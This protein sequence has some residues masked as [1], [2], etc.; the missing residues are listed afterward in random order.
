MR[1]ARKPVL[2]CTTNPS[3]PMTWIALDIGGANIKVADGKGFA[4]SS[5][6]PL[7]KKPRQLADALRT[8]IAGARRPITSP[9]R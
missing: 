9:R 5:V 8:L 6:F 7:W 3:P 1:P 4:I 2:R